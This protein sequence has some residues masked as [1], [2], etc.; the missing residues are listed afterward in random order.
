MTRSDMVGMVW[1]AD[2]GTA[3]KSPRPPSDVVDSAR[4]SLHLEVSEAVE[5]AFG[6]HMPQLRG[7]APWTNSG[8]DLHYKSLRFGA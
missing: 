4:Y 7:Q 8:F 5:A 2:T 1:P 6:R 3:E